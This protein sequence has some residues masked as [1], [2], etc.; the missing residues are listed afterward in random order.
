MK[1]VI[2]PIKSYL[3]QA[4]FEWCT[5]CG[6][7]PHL[8]VLVT[9]DVRVPSDYVRNGEIVL[10]IGQ[11]ATHALKITKQEITFMGRF[12]G[13][14]QEVSVPIFNV[15]AIFAKE[16]GQGISFEITSSKIAEH[17]ESNNPPILKNSLKLISENETLLFAKDASKTHN[18][19][20][21]K[22]APK[23]NKKNNSKHLKIIK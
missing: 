8:S 11:L 2:P 12:A 15:L 1:P 4:I 21:S 17:Q 6:F 7:T 19:K 20:S 3:I 13:K 16:N 23:Q 10:N 18:K 14:P 5:D 22:K 9:P